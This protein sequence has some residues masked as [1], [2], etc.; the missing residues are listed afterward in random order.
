MR[1]IPFFALCLIST[2]VFSFNGIVLMGPPGSG[3]GT[4]SSLAREQANFVHISPG[5]LLRA[6][7]T[8]QSEV[9]LQI[10]AKVEKGEIIDNAI[11][12]SLIRKQIIECIENGD[13]FILDGFPQSTAN[14]HSLV[15]LHEEYPELDL[16]FIQLFATE[17]CC[18][19]RMSSRQLCKN[20]GAIFNLQFAP[21]KRPN[22]CDD[23]EGPL[24]ARSD[25]VVE[26]ARRRYFCYK[27]RMEE[28]EII[29]RQNGY[30]IQQ[31]NTCDQIEVTKEEEKRVI[32]SLL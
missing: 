30:R 8:K 32:N 21:P 16:F 31:I 1:Y 13:L 6:E 18:V 14:A 17:E 10:K 3:K 4:F 25:D 2:V 19:D 26:H 20:C 5:N 7:V 27:Q 9:G 11:V 12:Y 22:T 23:C 15:A 28:V 29:L 24:S